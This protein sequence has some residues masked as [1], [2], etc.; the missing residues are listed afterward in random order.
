MQTDENGMGIP[1]PDMSLAKFLEYEEGFQAEMT[2]LSDTHP[3]G[4]VIEFSDGE[5]RTVLADGGSNASAPVTDETE[6]SDG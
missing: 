1:I 5:R 2:R 4:I 6:D 3:D